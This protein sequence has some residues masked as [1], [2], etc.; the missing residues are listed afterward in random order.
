MNRMLDLIKTLKDA[1][2]A[3]Y[4]Y[5]N[6]ILSDREYDNL[7]DKLELLEK[8]T[9]IIM[10]D[11]PTQ[12]V[13][14]EILP[15]LKKVI[16]STPMLS[17]DKT[18]SINDLEKF[19][20]NKEGVLSWKL[21]GLTI[22]LKYQEGKLI[23]AITRGSGGEIGEDV[24]HTIRT[25]RKLP[26]HIPYREYLEIRGECF[27]SYRT[28]KEIN[29]LNP[30]K[31]KNPRNLA[32]GTVR[33]LDSNTA[34]ERSLEFQAFAIVQSSKTFYTKIEQFKFLMSIGIPVV[35]HRLISSSKKI[36]EE[37]Q[38]FHPHK[39]ENPVDGLI[40]EINDLD[41]GKSLGVTTH[42]PLNIMAFKW[43][44]EVVE[45]ILTD[46]EWSASR[47][48]LLNPVAIFEPVEIEGTTVSRASLHN[49]SIFN[50]LKLGIG[51]KIEVYKANMITPQIYQNLT[52]SGNLEVPDRCP[53]CGGNT[54]IV[55]ENDSAQL[56][57]K[58][59]DCN[60]KIVG[61]LQHFCDK[62]S[63]DI[64]GVSK[65]TLQT[66]VDKEIIRDIIDILSLPEKN[67][68]VA[69]IKKLPGFGERSVNNLID[70]IHKARTE[71]PLNRF[72]RALGIP[73]IG[74]SVSKDINKHCQGDW[75]LFQSKMDS[76]YDWRIIPDF[77]EVMYNCLNTYWNENRN[78]ILEMLKYITFAKYNIDN[79]HKSALNILHDK[80]ICVTGKLYR[81]T[82]REE[83]AQKI[84]SLGGK[85]VSGV[86]KKTHFLLTND[87][88]SGSSKNKKAAELNIPIITE[89]DFIEMIK[90]EI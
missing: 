53:V 22:V 46:I 29:K 37:M 18:K 75:D 16:H 36:T 25:C 6:P 44:D 8:Q 21:D 77:G 57:C 62:N 19:L 13:Q 67:D 58:N 65:A 80:N 26:L 39:Y 73:N 34:R 78:Q 61:R 15:E 20:G 40:L 43:K 49:V 59:I 55:M 35:E 45:T 10:N 50:N 9:G 60:S 12:K 70:S 28:F 5:D 56:Y 38:N 11:S 76:E 24:T 68:S 88:G 90:G 87:T 81:F 82:N 2:K 84:E 41:Y 1:S 64:R 72:I 47:T 83:L 42:H 71:L 48:G 89:T 4:K 63:L 86:S 52:Q 23:Q 66:L 17:A 33:Q 14:G 32:S 85:V 54:E 79:T 74:S 69:V 27:I 51:D 7:Y 3:Y 31:Y 30:G